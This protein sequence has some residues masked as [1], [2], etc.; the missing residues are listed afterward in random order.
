MASLGLA[1]GSCLNAKQGWWRGGP[2]FKKQPD[3]AV[4]GFFS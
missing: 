1:S 2:G 3:A 4:S